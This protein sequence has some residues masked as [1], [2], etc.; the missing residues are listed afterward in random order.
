MSSFFD[1]DEEIGSLP[2]L[3]PPVPNSR[4]SSNA[5][6][7]SSHDRGSSI[8]SGSRS[9]LSRLESISPNGKFERISILDDDSRLRLDEGDANGAGGLA[10]DGD[11]GDEMDLDDVKRMGRIWLR[12]RGTVEILH[13]EGDLVDAL[14]DKLEQ[15]VGQPSLVL[16]AEKHI[17][18][19]EGEL[20]SKGTTSFTLPFHEY[21]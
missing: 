17:G 15:Q 9:F 8:A 5:H 3:S 12:E 13:W 11:E 4:F 14:F 21:P 7:S 10:L 19:L 20:L 16:V 2:V 18:R 1:E 6:A